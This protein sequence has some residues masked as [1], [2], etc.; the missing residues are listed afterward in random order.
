MA[1]FRSS[2]YA[3]S[4]PWLRGPVGERLMYGFGVVLDA[5][6]E[7][8]GQ[9]VRARFPG[10]GPA[11]ALPLIGAD[12][13]IVRGFAESD[14]SYAARLVRWL[15]DWRIAGSAPSVLGQLRGYFLASR[16]RMRTIDDSGNWVTLASDD[17]LSWVRGAGWNWDGLM[18]WWRFWA[19]IY[20]SNGPWQTEGTWSDG[21]TSWGDGGTWGTTA[22]PDEVATLRAIVA[23]WKGAHALPQWVIVAFDDATFTP[24]ASE[25]DGSWGPWSKYVGGVQIPSRIDSARY[26]DG[27]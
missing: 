2:L 10:L 1:S 3:I 9:G 16:P 15:D 27:A 24:G 19:V 11:D 14:A 13:Q 17:T 26:F 6:A 25:P 18:R 8:A 21:T 22:T 20:P 5:V 7:W 23:Q 12:R 4:P